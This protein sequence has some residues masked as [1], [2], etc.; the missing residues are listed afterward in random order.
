MALSKTTQ[1]HDEIQQWA[2]QR[3]AI[4]S[5][6]SSTGRKGETGILRFEFP[7]AKN[8][9]DSALNEISWDE[10]F[11]KFDASGLALVY[12]EKTAGGQKSNFNK[13]VHPEN[14]KPKA[15]KSASGR[16]SSSGHR[17]TKKAS[18]TTRKTAKR[19]TTKRATTK[20]ASTRRRT[21]AKG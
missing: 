18:A 21:A 3:G 19:S 16:S 14:A 5:E 7:G 12:Q 9:N 20:A 8:A 4:P 15:K 10:F 13:L 1:D 6:V 17:P 2:E 11:E